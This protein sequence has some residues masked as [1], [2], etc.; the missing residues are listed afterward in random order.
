[1]VVLG[2]VL[3]LRIIAA[4]NVAT[5]HTQAQV[6][7]SIAHRQAFLTPL[8]A[9]RHFLNLAQVLAPSVFLF[10]PGKQAGDR[11]AKHTLTSSLMISASHL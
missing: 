7:P 10:G 8:R 5:D 1:M 11:I 9:G 6:H 3:I 4:T 2:S